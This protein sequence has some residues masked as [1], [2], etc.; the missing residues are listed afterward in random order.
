MTDP[1]F[2]DPMTGE[3][4]P[5]GTS[6]AIE[7]RVD[8]IHDP[9][10]EPDEAWLGDWMT[11]SLVELDAAQQALTAGYQKR[12]R[13]L[14]AR[15]KYLEVTYND[16]LEAVVRSAL[17]KRR[18]SVDFAYGRVGLRRSKRRIVEDEAAALEWAE[19]HG[20][21]DAISRPAPTLLKSHLPDTCPHMM[22]EVSESLSVTPHKT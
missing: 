19:S 22:I 1:L 4:V 11:K 7:I 18:K 5:D 6:G 16:R 21:E 12:L 14:K 15:R 2:I 10:G 9:P 3:V 8:E 20:C 13:S 17:T